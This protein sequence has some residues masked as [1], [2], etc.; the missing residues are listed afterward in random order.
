MLCGRPVRPGGHGGE[1]TGA[2]RSGWVPPIARTPARGDLVE[3][4]DQIVGVTAEQLVIFEL[5][6]WQTRS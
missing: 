3:A 1:R 5:T 6:P 2:R 4:Q